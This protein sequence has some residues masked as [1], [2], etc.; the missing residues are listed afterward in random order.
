M[1]PHLDLF[2]CFSPHKLNKLNQ[3][4]KK[5]RSLE[6]RIIKVKEY[7]SEKTETFFV[8]CKQKKKNRRKLGLVRFLLNKILSHPTF[9]NHRYI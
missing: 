9:S 2:N 7:A 6:L 5:A 8:I 3:F 4:G 1:N